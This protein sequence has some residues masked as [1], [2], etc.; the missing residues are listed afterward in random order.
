MTSLLD[1]EAYG[2]N[3]KALFT[4]KIFRGEGMAL[5]GMNWKTVTPPDN[6]VGFAIE[7]QEPG[8]TQF[9]P[10][11]NR[12]SFLANDGS[13]NKNILS[14]RLSPIQKFRWVHFPFNANLAGDF[15][16]QVTPVFMDATHV[17]SYGEPQQAKINLFGETYPG[18]L[19][20]EFT[21]GFVASQAFADKFT[22]NGDISTLIPANP[23]DGLKFVS[24]NPL[25]NQALAWMGYGAR[26]A[27]LDLLNEA[28]ADKT[29]QVR[30]TAYDFNEPEIV[31]QLVK[32]GTRLQVII[33]DSGTHAPPTS[34]ESQA[35]AMLI[36]SGAKVQRQ[37]VGDLQHNKTI[38]VQGAV[39][40]AVGGSTNY[41]W[42]GLYAQNNNAVIVHGKDNVQLFFDAFNNLWKNP[43]KPAGFAKTI[44][45]NWNKL[46]LPSVGNAAIAFSPHNAG[47]ALLNDIANDMG[48]TTSSL[49]FSLA[50]LYQTKGPILN[51]IEKVTS[52]NKIFVYGISDKKV[53][54]LDIK[55]PDGND[56][57][58][59]PAR[60]L[61]DVPEPFKS[62][63]SDGSGIQMHHKFVVIDFDQ[64]TARVY[65]GSYN[66]S[67]AADVKN[68]E[69]LFL[70]NDRKIAVSYMI[71]AVAMFDHYEF[72]DALQ[73]SK[74]GKLFLHIPPQKTG[75]VAWWKE[76]Y[77]DPQKIRDR[78]LFSK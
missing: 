62:E 39:Q 66:F 42:R 72:R 7:Y 59:F 29:A 54:G 6:F 15:T 18:E 38:A 5:L 44:S 71:E 13:V 36:K 69:N 37:H 26:K 10:V 8:G 50:F 70:F 1:F 67:S 57:V 63:A 33:D 16:Y 35:A 75:D 55:I 61:Q 23:D 45:A 78:V 20:I 46:N 68:G 34:A 76:D 48:K 21:R 56:P 30:V 19:N 43:N 2:T 3:D 31:S 53:G 58:A 52:D 47:N 40:S 12:L 49:L 28:I 65:T 64:P 4:L 11:M 25:E 24:T 51:V 17:L 9:F 77:T 32:L 73:T 27:I 41:S 14:S 74:T 22:A 60:L